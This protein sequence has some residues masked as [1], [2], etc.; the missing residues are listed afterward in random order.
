M[1]LKILHACAQRAN[2]LRLSFTKNTCKSLIMEHIFVANF[3]QTT[4]EKNGGKIGP[5][6]IDS[7]SFHCKI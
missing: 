5:I 2:F 1:K 4:Y 3:F 6:L 7:L